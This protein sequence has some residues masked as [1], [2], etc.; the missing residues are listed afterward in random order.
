MKVSVCCLHRLPNSLLSGQRDGGGGLGGW[1]QSKLS[2]NRSRLEGALS[3][4]VESV[5]DEE[6][7][8]VVVVAVTV[9]NNVLQRSNGTGSVG[10]GGVRYCVRGF[11]F[12]PKR[13]L[14]TE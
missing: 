14:H 2:V 9:P 11:Q 4:Q 1:G 8:A 13:V 5:A 12:C 3:P 7:E 10:C 6:G